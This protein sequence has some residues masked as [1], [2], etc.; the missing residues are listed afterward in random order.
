MLGLRVGYTAGFAFCYHLVRAGTMS[1]LN[2][3]DNRD[4]VHE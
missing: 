3:N 4:G 2:N 1:S